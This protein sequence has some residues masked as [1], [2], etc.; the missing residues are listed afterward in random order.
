[1]SGD[2]RAF[3]SLISVSLFAGECVFCKKLLNRCAPLCRCCGSFEIL[4]PPLCPK[5]GQPVSQEIG[6]CGRCTELK[7]R[8]LDSVRSLFWLTEEAS[9]VLHGIK[10]QRQVGF[11][12]F[13]K[14]QFLNQDFFSAVPDAVLVPVPVSSS[15]YVYRG[16]NQATKIAEWIAEERGLSI[17]EGLIKVR[18]TESQSM[19][20][21]KERAQNLKG[22]FQW[23]CR[24]EVPRRVI[25]VDDVFT[26]GH[27]L[28]ACAQPL[29]KVGVESVHGLTL[30]RATPRSL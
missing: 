13:V 1:M 27:T 20:G 9:I 25:L 12:R 17:C 3:F 19:L 24:S 28:E 30:F 15:R 5:C 23:D 26:T 10:Y 21:K 11:L 29:K 14:K 7:F 18:E 6:E 8:F 22:L 16:F 2:L 4:P